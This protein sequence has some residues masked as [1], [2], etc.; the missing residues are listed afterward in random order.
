MSWRINDTGV[1]FTVHVGAMVTLDRGFVRATEDAADLSIPGFS[2]PD[3]YVPPINFHGHAFSP[4]LQ[5]GDEFITFSG[6]DFVAPLGDEF[7]ASPGNEFLVKNWHGDSK[8][9][10]QLLFPPHSITGKVK[11]FFNQFVNLT[12]AAQLS[13]LWAVP[14]FFVSSKTLTSSTTSFCLLK[15]SGI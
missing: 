4:L 3:F 14:R 15:G 8:S 6:N 12:L 13:S 7:V 10:C 5:K 11:Y 9:P 1:F 2:R